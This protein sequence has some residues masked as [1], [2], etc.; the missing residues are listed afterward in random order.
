MPEEHNQ[1]EKGFQKK[2]IVYKLQIAQYSYYTSIY[3]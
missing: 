3:D 1:L 2:T